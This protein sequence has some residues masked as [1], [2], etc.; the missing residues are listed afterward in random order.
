[1][2][3]LA[4][5]LAIVSSVWVGALA[6]TEAETV[7]DWS[8]G[9]STWTTQ[10]YWQDANV[11]QKYTFTQNKEDRVSGSQPLP[12]GGVVPDSGAAVS[13]PALRPICPRCINGLAGTWRLIFTCALTIIPRAATVT[14]STARGKWKY[15]ITPTAR[16]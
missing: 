12:P 10:T 13:Q 9:E 4:V 3:G 15:S 6:S 16:L 2:S 7:S 1:M 5:G 14:P 11:L 8:E